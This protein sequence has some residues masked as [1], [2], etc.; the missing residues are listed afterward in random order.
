MHSDGKR[1]KVILTALFTALSV[2][3]GYLMAA[4]PNVEL[5]T[6]SVFISGMFT[7]PRWGA[8]TGVLSITVFSLFN[9]Y[10][11]ALPPLLAAQAAGF[12]LAG[13]CGGI[14]RGVIKRRGMLAAA[15]SGLFIT[16]IYDILTTLAS[17]YVVLGPDGF[18]GGL[19]GFF[20]ASAIFIMIHTGVNTLVFSQAATAVTRISYFDDAYKGIS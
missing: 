20:W 11:A 7:G 9:P 4:V 10:G 2:V 14:L 16:F 3:L 17:A 5:M 15:L 12:S 1:Q 13:A 6:I 19:A 18:A 8:L